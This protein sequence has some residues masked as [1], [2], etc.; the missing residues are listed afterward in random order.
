MITMII[1]FLLGAYVITP[2]MIYAWYSFTN[3]FR[4]QETYVEPVK[5]YTVEDWLYGRK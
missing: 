2:L 1:W 5:P 3:M 4:K